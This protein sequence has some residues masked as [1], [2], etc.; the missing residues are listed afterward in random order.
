MKLEELKE[1]TAAELAD[2]RRDLKVEMMNLRVQKASGQL[3]NPARIK[4]VRKTIARIE[5]LLSEKRISQ[6]ETK[7]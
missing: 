7:S 1:K 4:I 5:T 2:E 3:E 6:N